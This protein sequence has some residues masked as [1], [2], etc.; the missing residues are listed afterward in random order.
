MFLI[1][2]D[3]FTYPDVL[4][5][6]SGFRRSQSTQT[7]RCLSRQRSLWTHFLQ[8]GQAVVKGHS[9]GDADVWLINCK[10]H[11]DHITHTFKVAWWNLNNLASCFACLF[12]EIFY[13][14]LLL[15]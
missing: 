10:L 4:D 15:S 3:I 6:F 7:G 2:S 8:P 13:C 11:V 14:S 12:L 5:S 1:V 9:T